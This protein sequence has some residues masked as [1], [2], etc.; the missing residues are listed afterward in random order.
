MADA[1]LAGSSPGTALAAPGEGVAVG[2]DGGTQG[3]GAAEA[4]PPELTQLTAPLSAAP[5]FAGVP[6]VETESPE[7]ELLRLL[8]EPGL[9]RRA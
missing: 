3:I 7:A 1:Q 8:T 2:S 9:R 6:D 5:T 4:L